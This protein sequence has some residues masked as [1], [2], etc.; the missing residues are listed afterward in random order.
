MASIRSGRGVAGVALLLASA[1]LAGGASASLGSCGPFA[2]VAADSFCP[3]VLEVFFL[4]VTTGTTPT[5]YDPATAVTRLQMAAFLSRS[6]DGV[7]RRGSRRAAMKQFWTSQNPQALALTTVGSLP[8]SAESDGMDI[9]VSNRDGGSVSR[10]R[11]SDGSVIAG[12]SGATQ[13]YGVLVAMGRIFATGQVIPGALY[14]INPSLAAGA[15]TTVASNL[16]NNAQGIA[17]DGGRIW[18]AN[19]ASVSIVTPGASLPWTVTTVSTG[20]NGPVGALFDGSNIWVTDVS[21]SKL[22]KLNANGAIL[23][24][25]TMGS[26]PGL[27][28]FDGT[29]IWVPNV[30]NDTVTVVRAS[31]GNVLTTLTGNG[32]S[33]PYGAAFDGQRVLITNNTASSVSLWKAADLTTIG[34]F[35]TGTST[36]PWGAGS[37]GVSFWVV[38][39]NSNHVAR[40]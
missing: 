4:G 3:F 28:V 15:V 12:W 1:V 25:V 34:T 2:D 23:Q 8:I 18:T 22:L 26:A 16:G 37:D 32:L 20:F 21:A 27:P 35:S 33:G 38:L 5:T 30:G 11:G 36:G 24:T 13:A 10:V 40:F 9:W 39:H 7:L 31:N 29:N 17:F 6:V 19:D 14:R